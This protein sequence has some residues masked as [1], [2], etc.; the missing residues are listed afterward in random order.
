MASHAA[1]FL[2]VRRRS[3]RRPSRLSRPTLPA[4]HPQF[5]YLPPIAPMGA[6]DAAPRALVAE[7]FS[8]TL[9]EGAAM[10]GANLGPTRASNQLGGSRRHFAP[11]LRAQGCTAAGAGPAG[12]HCK[13]RRQCRGTAI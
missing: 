12:A 1:A 9:L 7:L 5:D 13:R 4:A 8:P 6:G 11:P 3:A 10:G 2:F